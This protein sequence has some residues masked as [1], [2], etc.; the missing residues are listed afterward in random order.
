MKL[1]GVYRST[2]YFVSHYRV[3]AEV[4]DI[5]CCDADAC[6]G[7]DAIR[8]TS[9]LLVDAHSAFFSVTLRNCALVIE[10]HMLLRGCSDLDPV[11]AVAAIGS[12]SLCLRV[13]R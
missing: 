1:L 7:L 12:F 8:F 10:Q 13:A 3:A 2:N 5:I 11:A 4:K 6:S 9:S